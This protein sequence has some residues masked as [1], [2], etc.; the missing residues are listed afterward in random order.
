MFN[1]EIDAALSQEEA[2]FLYHAARRMK[3][4]VV[5]EI[6][7]YLGGSAAMLAFGSLEGSQSMIYT[8]DD[9]SCKKEKVKKKVYE[10]FIK[11]IIEIG[12]SGAVFPIVMDSIKASKIFP[13]KVDILFID[14]DHKYISVKADWNAWFPKVEVGG[15][16]MLHDTG[17][18]G[19]EGPKK[20]GKEMESNKKVEFKGYYYSIGIFKKVKE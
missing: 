2:G 7:T 8:V 5:V 11:K 14:G 20:F 13:L 19:W 16:I 10:R 3:R 9:F 17:P 4:G 1:V 6:G 15:Y 18:N 12:C